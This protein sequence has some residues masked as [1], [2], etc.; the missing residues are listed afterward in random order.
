VRLNRSVVCCSLVDRRPG[1]G[2]AVYR[3][4]AVLAD[5][6]RVPAGTA[7]PRRT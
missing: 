7:I 2:A 6:T 4:E 5:G 1:R 3:L